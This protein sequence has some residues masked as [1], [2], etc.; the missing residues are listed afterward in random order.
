MLEAFAQFPK[1]KAH[2]ENAWQKM[3]NKEIHVYTN[4]NVYNSINMKNELWTKQW[5]TAK[6]HW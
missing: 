3:K 1:P 2:V 4:L 6:S 5:G